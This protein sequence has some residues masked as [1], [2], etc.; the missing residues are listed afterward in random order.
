MVYD[1][2]MKNIVPVSDLQ[3]QA[4]SILNEVRTT[5]EPVIITQRGRATAVLVSAEHYAK[6]EEDLA[7]LD[8]LELRREIELAEKEIAAGNTISMEEAKRRLGY[9]D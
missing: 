5:N 7:L 9:K 2:N 4:A 1:P 6:I 3:K 8:E